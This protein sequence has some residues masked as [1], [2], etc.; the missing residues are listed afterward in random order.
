M[1]KK[2]RICYLLV[3][4]ILLSPNYPPPVYNFCILTTGLDF[5]LVGVWGV[6]P[7][8]ISALRIVKSKYYPLGL[9]VKTFKAICGADKN[10]ATSF[11]PSPLHSDYI[12]FS[13]GIRWM[14]LLCGDGGGKELPRF[15]LVYY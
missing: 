13:R 4:L 14:R 7:Y 11:P 3:Q 15:C 5:F 6:V 10:D 1:K 2:N 8:L 12:W 9:G